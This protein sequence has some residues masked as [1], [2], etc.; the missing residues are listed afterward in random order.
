M[1]SLYFFYDPTKHGSPFPKCPFHQLTGFHCPGCGSQR[2][3]NKILNGDIIGGIR[4][5]YLIPFAVFVIL[6]QLIYYLITKYTTKTM[7]NI[8]HNAK[9]TNVILI[10]VILFWVLRNVPYFPFTEIAP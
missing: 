1:L 2:A 5:N 7:K 8:F 3:L 4:H 10:L 9:V 6:Y